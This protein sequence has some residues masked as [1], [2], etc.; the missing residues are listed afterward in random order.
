MRMKFLIYILS[1][2]LISL[3]AE[4]RAQEL[5][6]TESVAQAILD[7]TTTE[8]RHL[9]WQPCGERFRGHSPEALEYARSIAVPLVEA[10]GDDLDPWWMAAQLM[11]ESGMNPCAF[12]SNEF[13]RLRRALGRRPTRRDVLHLLR[14]PQARQDH[15]IRA[16][17]G[18][19]A[20]FRWPGT[21]ARRVGIERP[22]QLVDMQ[23]SLRA[24]GAA[25][26]L[27]RARCEEHPVFSGV[28]TVPIRS[29]GRSR[30]I[31]WRFSCDETFWAIHN[32][33]SATTVRRRYILN[34]QRRFRAGPQ[35]WKQQFI[36]QHIE[37]ERPA[38]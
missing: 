28:D 4:A 37:P 6:R 1:L 25:L 18:G 30:V 21:V 34:V 10:A 20:Q 2:I 3:A 13:A 15:G 5:T 11:Q 32:S 35:S 33:G 31:H 16:M 36:D 12:S 27:Y 14:N 38:G 17:D 24:F 19:L 29:T 9:W 7:M 26:R 22:E 8:R 23:V